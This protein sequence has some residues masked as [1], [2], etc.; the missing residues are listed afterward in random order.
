[1]SKSSEPLWPLIEVLQRQIVPQVQRHGMNNVIVGAPFWQQF[2]RREAVLPEDVFITRQTLKSKKTAIK[3]R[4]SGGTKSLVN[5]VWP[6][7]GLCSTIMPVLMFVVGGRVALPL[8]DYVVH[9]RSGHALLIPAGTPH[10]S[11]SLLCTESSHAGNEF[12][13]MFSVI[14]WGRGVAC[15]LNHT[16]NGEHWSHRTPGENCHMF[17]TKANFYLETLTEEAVSRASH[18]QQ[19]CDGLLLALMTLLLREIEE[20]HAFQPILLT[21]TAIDPSTPPNLLEQNPITRAQ[22]YINSYLASPLTIDQVAA[23]VFMSRA[24][25]TRQFRKTTGKSFI[26]YVTERRLQEA[27]VL[28]HD[29][30]WS[31]EKISE[32]VGIT[33]TRLRHIFF[34]YQ[35]QTPSAYREQSRQ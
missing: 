33:P 32:F 28:L 21:E 14:P 17:S 1:M 4:S 15:W 25:F 34:E 6:K 22:A 24:Y 8:G 30:N 19:H 27:K 9:C 5:A 20:Q 29:T 26:Q 31:I 2:Q 13:D 18:F 16:K 11:G 7:D 35:R 10:P 3:S 12:N 23:H